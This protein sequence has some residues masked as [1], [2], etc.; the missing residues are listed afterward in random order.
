MELTFSTATNKLYATGLEGG[1]P[2]IRAYVVSLLAPAGPIERLDTSLGDLPEHVV[3]NDKL[4]RGY[5]LVPGAIKVFSTDSDTLI[6]TSDKP[7]CSP[8]VL[9]ISQAT[10]IVYGGGVSDKGECLVQFDSDGR[11][12]RENVVAP[13]VAGQNM[14]VQR[15]AVDSATGDVLYTNPSS[16]GR[17]DLMLRER[18][19]TPVGGPG[20]IQDLGFEPKTDTAYITVGQ[21]PVISPARISVLDGHTG[22]QEGEFSGPGWTSE[23]AS[24]GDGRLFV[25]FFN[26]NDLYMLSGATNTPT[27]FA[28]LGDIPGSSPSDPKWLFVDTVGHRLFVSPGGDAHKILLYQY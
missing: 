26:S 1:P 23:F 19:R 16:V 5:A 9:A 7:S 17:A 4:R 25:A 21:F 2:R 15:I 11:I 22:K 24:T 27:K 3:V 12:V 6:S 10:G 20:E 18:W 14:L 28:S 13:H 8:Q